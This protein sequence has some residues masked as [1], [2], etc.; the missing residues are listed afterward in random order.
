V[1]HDTSNVWVFR[2]DEVD[3][4]EDELDEV[5]DLHEASRDPVNRAMEESVIAEQTRTEDAYEHRISDVLGPAALAPDEPH[6]CE[7]CRGGFP[8]GVPLK[9]LLE[10]DRDPLYAR[11]Y[12]WALRVFAWSRDSYWNSGLRNR[13]MFRVLVNAYLVPIKIT[14]A[15]TEEERDDEHAP[16]IAWL[17][18]DLALTY[19]SRTRESLRALR[20]MGLARAELD[21]MVGEADALENAI[22]ERRSRF[23]AV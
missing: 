19:L 11:A 16:R 3:A 17:E 18:Y 5:F 8:E 23:P 1:P 21:W 9:E 4:L 22:S 12:R 7:H 20:A 10:R 6:E 2:R 13:D 15:L 14:F